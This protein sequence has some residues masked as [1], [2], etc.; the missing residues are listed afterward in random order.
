MNLG[1][2]EAVIESVEPIE[3]DAAS[4]RVTARFEDGRVE[5]AEL[6]PDLVPD[7]LAAGDRVTVTKAALYHRWTIK[8]I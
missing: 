8:K 4:V 7:G 2:F 6:R 3:G 5:S 1:D